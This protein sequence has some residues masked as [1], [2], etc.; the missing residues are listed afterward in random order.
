MAP[1]PRQAP[2]RCT[3]PDKARGETA[4]LIRCILNRLDS[5]GLGRVGRRK[6]HAVADG[7]YIRIRSRQILIDK[8]STI[9]DQPGGSGKLR[10][11]IDAYSFNDKIGLDL[12]PLRKTD[13]ISTIS[14]TPRSMPATSVPK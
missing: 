6:H 9:D 2:I 3:F 10:I 8:D 4:A 11:R 1:K 13:R 7:R 5:D 14:P 12:F